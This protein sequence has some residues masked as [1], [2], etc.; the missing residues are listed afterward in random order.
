MRFRLVPTDDRFFSLFNESA[1]NEC[2]SSPG[3]PDS[4]IGPC[5]QQMFD[6]GPGP[7]ADHG[8][9]VNMPNRQY[10]SVSCGVYLT[11]AGKVWVH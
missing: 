4:T 9:Y 3:P 1:Q 5:L 2:P 8:H 7:Y 10:T 6:E 11:P